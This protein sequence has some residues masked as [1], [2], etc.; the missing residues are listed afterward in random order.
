MAKYLL[1]VIWYPVKVVRIFKVVLRS[2]VLRQ[3]CRAAQLKVVQKTFKVSHP[4]NVLK[5]PLKV[6]LIYRMKAALNLLNVILFLH[7]VIF[8]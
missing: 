1:W 2:P 4:F 7:K 5:L 6:D 8:K 3:S